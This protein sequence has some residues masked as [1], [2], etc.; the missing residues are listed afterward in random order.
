M[1]KD[2]IAFMRDIAD[3]LRKVPGFVRDHYMSNEP[4]I[5]PRAPYFMKVTTLMVIIARV[6]DT[7]CNEA[8]KKYGQ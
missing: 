5:D 2:T 4:N 3:G 1:D 6:I 8:E 7:V